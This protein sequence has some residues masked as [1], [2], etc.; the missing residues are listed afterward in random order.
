MLSHTSFHISMVCRKAASSSEKHSG[1]PAGVI[2]MSIVEP[3]RGCDASSAG[4]CE[5]V[6]RE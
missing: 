6:K 2:Q 5:E 4:N 1:E 3:E